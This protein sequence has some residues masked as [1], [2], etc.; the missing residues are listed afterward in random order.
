MNLF[1][2]KFCLLLLFIKHIPVDSIFAHE[3]QHNEYSHIIEKQLLDLE[4]DR[5]DYITLEKYQKIS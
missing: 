2:F 1:K 3:Q 4:L 5:V